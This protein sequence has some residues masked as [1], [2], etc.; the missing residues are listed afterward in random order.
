[1]YMSSAFDLKDEQ[2]STVG[3]DEPCY[4]TPVAFM[5]ALQ[6]LPLMAMLVFHEMRK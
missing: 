6:M 5:R 1:M 4:N 2:V 3:I